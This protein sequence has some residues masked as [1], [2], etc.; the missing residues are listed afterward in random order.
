MSSRSKSQVNRTKPQLWEQVKREV[1]RGSKGGQPGK[2]SARKAQLSVSL[3]KSR[4][5]GYR[6]K[7][8][9]TNSLTKWSREKWGYIN[10]KSSRSRT[11]RYLP[12][13][14]RKNLSAKSKRSENIKKGSRRGKWVPYG[15]EVRKLMRRYGIT[16]SRGS[17]S[18]KTKSP[19]KRTTCWSGYVRVPGKKPGTKGSCRK[20]K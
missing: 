13:V 15:T 4:G 5:G 14:V 12:L 17:R 10:P 20:A 19:A 1:T 9:P 18:R 3:Y 2:W 8:S 16:S 6:G 7:K 11:G